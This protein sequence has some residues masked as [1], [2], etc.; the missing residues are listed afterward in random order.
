MIKIV[1]LPNSLNKEM[2]KDLKDKIEYI[3]GSLSDTFGDKIFLLS[4]VHEDDT[5]INLT[6]GHCLA[7]SIEIAMMSCMANG[8]HHTCKNDS[9]LVEDTSGRKH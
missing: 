6:N 1:P 7:C 4:I 2:A 5:V 9:N 3:L 8:L